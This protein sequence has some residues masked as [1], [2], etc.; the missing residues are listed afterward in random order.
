MT[1]N[2]LTAADRVLIPLQCEYYAMEGLTQL[3]NTVRLIQRELNP[4]LTLLGILLT[5]FDA[6]NNLSHQ[7]VDDRIT[8][9]NVCYTKLLRRPLW[10]R[11]R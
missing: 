7:V 3:L 4:K 11:W 5:M 9:Y 2:A 6:R 10:R 8:S 1:I